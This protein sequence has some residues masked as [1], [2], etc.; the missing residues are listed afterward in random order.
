MTFAYCKSTFPDVGGRKPV[1]QCETSGY[2]VFLLF[3]GL[4]LRILLVL[5]LV[6]CA[7]PVFS[8]VHNR[9]L[10]TL[11]LPPLSKPCYIRKLRNTADDGEGERTYSLIVPRRYHFAHGAPYESDLMFQT[12]SR[13]TFP[14]ILSVS[15]VRPFLERL[16]WPLP[17]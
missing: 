16:M 12:S 9:L 1:H 6:P 10:R 2:P 5:F 3:V 17:F 15:L 14:P 8:C 11:A 13:W 4:V 7:C